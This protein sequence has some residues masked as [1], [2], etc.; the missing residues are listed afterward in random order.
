M[1]YNPSTRRWEVE[2][3]EGR[4][5]HLHLPSIGCTVALA[6]VYECIVFPTS[7]EESQSHDPR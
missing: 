2:T 6:D 4:D 5:V 3:L 1:E 7:E